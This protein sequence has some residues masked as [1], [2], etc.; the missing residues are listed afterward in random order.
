MGTPT[1]VNMHEAKTKLSELGRRVWEG[2]EIVIARAREPNLDLLP[3][4]PRRQDR[5]P[6][7]WAQR[8]WIADDFDETDPET[9]AAFERAHEDRE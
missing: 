2:E 7:R 5:T 9:V 8:I 3:H 4:R 1:I 6:G